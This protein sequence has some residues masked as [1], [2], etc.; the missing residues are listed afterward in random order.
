[1]LVSSTPRLTGPQ[2]VYRLMSAFGRAVAVRRSGLNGKSSFTH[3]ELHRWTIARHCLYSTSTLQ[4]NSRSDAI[5][6]VGSCRQVWTLHV[7]GWAAT[8]RVRWTG[9]QS[10]AE[11]RGRG[12]H[13]ERPMDGV[14]RD[15]ATARRLW[16]SSN[17]HVQSTLEVIA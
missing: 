3:G 7:V 8:D 10:V 16:R 13:S 17:P 5:S 12:G 6:I 4:S 14:G 15:E 2:L 1:M 9:H 11:R